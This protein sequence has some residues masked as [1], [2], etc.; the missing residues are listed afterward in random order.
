LG[1]RCRSTL[2]NTITQVAKKEK[3]SDA[4]NFQEIKLS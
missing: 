4:L 1:L 2:H 3:K